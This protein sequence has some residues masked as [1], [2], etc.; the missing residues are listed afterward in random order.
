[1]FT[2]HGQILGLEIAA[3][4]HGRQLLR[5]GG[6]RCY[7]VSRDHLNLAKGGCKSRRGVGGYDFDAFHW[8][9]LENVRVSWRGFG[10]T[11]SA[12]KVPP[13]SLG[14]ISRLRCSSLHHFD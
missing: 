7:W 9:F 10:G 2:F 3:F 12:K 4:Y 11:F 6:L 13:S 8:V 5:H 14:L 1:M